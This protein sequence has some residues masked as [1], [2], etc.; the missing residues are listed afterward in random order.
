[1]PF[2]YSQFDHWV[3]TLVDLLQ[4]ATVLDIGPGAGKYGRIIRARA[5]QSTFTTHLT[6]IE[7]D[8]SYVD[9]YKLRDIYDVVTI[10]DAISLLKAPRCR[11]DLVMIGDCIE[12]MR[13][14]SAVDL[15]NFLIYRAG[16]ICV[17][18]PDRFVQDGLVGAGRADEPDRGLPTV[19]AHVTSSLFIH[20][21]N[22]GNR[23]SRS[24]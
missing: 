20:A 8:A 1:M 16:Y 6:A 10:D 12:H 14:S 21:Y 2:S 17:I 3:G 19:G 11:Y 13:K 4:P 22:D 18:Y 9:T 23:R 15:L 24:L 7:I 5:S